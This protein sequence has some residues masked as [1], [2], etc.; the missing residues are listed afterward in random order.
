[1][2]VIRL[3]LPQTFEQALSD[4]AFPMTGTPT[5]PIAYL[6]DEVDQESLKNALDWYVEESAA[7]EVS[8]SEI[9][10]K[11]GEQ[12]DS[13]FVDFESAARPSANLGFI[14]WLYDI[15]ATVNSRLRA[16]ICTI[17]KGNSVPPV[18]FEQTTMTLK[19]LSVV[20]GEQ[21]TVYD[22][23]VKHLGV[24]EQ[25]GDAN[26]LVS[27]SQKSVKGRIVV[28]MR[29]DSQL[30]GAYPEIALPKDIEVGSDE[31][32]VTLPVGAFNAESLN[33]HT[34]SK[35]AM[36]DMLDQINERRPESNWG[37]LSEYEMGLRYN[38]PPMRWL[39]ATEQNGVIYAVGR[40]LT[41]E[42][43]TYYKRAKMDNARVGTSLFAW[44]EMEGDTVTHL[45]LITIDLA[46]PARVGVP[47]TSAKPVVVT[48]EMTKPEGEEKDMLEERVRE[49]LKLEAS[50][51]VEKA[52]EAVIE[53]Q[54]E[55][56]SKV[57]ELQSELEKAKAETAEV[58]K[59]NAELLGLSLTYIIENSVKLEENRPII[60]DIIAGVNDENL[61]KFKTL[62]DVK[63]AVRDVL[64]RDSVKKLNREALADAMGDPQE[65]P[66][67]ASAS[68]GARHFVIPK[69]GE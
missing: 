20:V 34:Y 62:D 7:L 36:Q 43:R 49:L 57:T 41:D 15:D 19:D 44:A 50:A 14:F 18:A 21:E 51:D 9:G 45:D 56:A 6:S 5:I 67:D 39:A 22:L 59:I 17:G 29:I 10:R 52:V 27:E 30:K 64:K 63:A 61:V 47:L 11:F 33:G 46:D 12:E 4:A 60:R 69:K 53:Q 25:V 35:S 40:A 58:Q 37:H 54:A 31:V 55:Q 28:E 65:R 42:A 66:V 23:S 1:L 68:S 24:Q 2:A 13:V 26:M 3:M 8:I 32:F 48:T 38:N 16:E